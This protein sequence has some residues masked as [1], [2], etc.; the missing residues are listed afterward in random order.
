MAAFSYET[1][2][3]LLEPISSQLVH[4]FFLVFCEFGFLM[5]ALSYE[6]VTDLLEPI[7]SQLVAPI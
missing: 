3:D 4:I 1:V 6:T 7:S 5:A 2:T